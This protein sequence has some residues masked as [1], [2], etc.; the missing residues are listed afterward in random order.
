M[1][2]YTGGFMEKVFCR[3]GLLFCKKK[4]IE[5]KKVWFGLC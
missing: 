5:G 3:M 2:G 4:R 1:P